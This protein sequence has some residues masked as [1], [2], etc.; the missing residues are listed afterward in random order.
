M[1]NNYFKALLLIAFILV[2]N[3]VLAQGPPPPPPPIEG[4][5]DGGIAALFALGVGYGIKRIR[6]HQKGR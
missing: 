1:A 4:P 5:I 2:A 3:S 6:D